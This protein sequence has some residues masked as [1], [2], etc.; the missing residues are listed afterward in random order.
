M[1]NRKYVAKK[2]EIKSWKSV[3]EYY[4]DLKIRGIASVEEL[5]KWLQDRSELDAVMSEELAWR[6]I[7]MNCNTEDEALS[8]AY[9]KFV[10]EIQPEVDK[11][12]F[13]L[14]KILY[15]SPFAKQLKGEDYRIMLRSVNNNIELFREANIPIKAELAQAEQE[16]GKITGAMTI[17]HNDKELTLQQANA[18]LQEND[19]QLREKIFKA[20]WERRLQDKDNLNNLII[21]LIGKRQQL[22]KNADFDNYRDYKFRSMAR[23]DYSVEDCYNFHEAI[24]HTV[25]PVL[26]KLHQKRQNK[27][28]VKHLK[29][30]DLSVDEDAKAA[31]RPFENANELIEKTIKCFDR[32]KPKYGSFLRQ[33]NELN[34]FD[35][36]ARKGKAPGGFN[37]PL[38]ESNIPFI[39]MNSS[40]TV[41]DVETMVHE[42]GHAIHAFL[43]K[44][45]ELID[46]KETPSEVAE[47][48]SMS[49]E[50]ISMEHWDVY[51][52]DKEELKRAK[53][54][55]LEGIIHTLAW[56]ANIDK[57]QHLLYLEQNISIT[58]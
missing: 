12:D 48:A 24:Q 14:D 27:L 20:V 6:Y 34:F 40:G 35:L 44:D 3:E 29:P 2:L 46:F 9:N 19:R 16:Y 53:R 28:N 49:M 5:V 11:Y 18:L 45:L 8:E 13:E 41:R 51:F 58:G 26:E 56:V 15:S 32:V 55:Q 1:N 50:L 23:F 17:E 37:Y 22:A 43:C 42:G 30:W 10:S 57:F 38:Y 31:M 54:E 4:K 33:M 21:S 39:F 36:E 52:A 47:L 25:V 7:K